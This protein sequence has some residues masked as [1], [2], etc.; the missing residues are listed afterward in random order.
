VAGWLGG[1]RLVGSAGPGLLV[2]L[3]FDLIAL[4]PT[5]NP[6]RDPRLKSFALLILDFLIRGSLSGTTVRTLL[7]S[8]NTIPCFSIWGPNTTSFMILYATTAALAQTRA[9]R[10]PSYARSNGFLK[11]A[12]THASFL[13]CCLFFLCFFVFASSSLGKAFSVNPRFFSDCCEKL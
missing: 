11:T 12:D 3:L 1:A 5:G 10:A 9:A 4:Q 6:L 7:A 2:P 13:S 8:V